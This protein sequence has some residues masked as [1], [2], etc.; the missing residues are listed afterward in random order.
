MPIA[1]NHELVTSCPLFS[2]RHLSTLLE[3]RLNV[4]ESGSC[5]AQVRTH[6]VKH[7]KQNQP[8]NG[9]I[10][11]RSSTV[12]GLL[13]ILIRVW[14]WVMEGRNKNWILILQ[15]DLKPGN[16]LEKAWVRFITWTKPPIIQT[17]KAHEDGIKLL[18]HSWST[19]EKGQTR[20]RVAVVILR[21]SADGCLPDLNIAS[22]MPSH[23]QKFAKSMS[24]RKMWSGYLK[25]PIP[26]AWS[27]AA[28][29]AWSP[30][31]KCFLAPFHWQNSGDR[32]ICK[33]GI[34]SIWVW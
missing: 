26:A 20:V 10:T 2:R 23:S 33:M 27:S 22:W 16:K 13:R 15:R 34:S 21:P 7:C 11:T 30:F 4:D 12:P 6:N 24:F 25:P 17:C 29:F 28:D 9:P 14:L 8:P 5:F 19:W 3:G 32:N 18:P 1:M 31:S